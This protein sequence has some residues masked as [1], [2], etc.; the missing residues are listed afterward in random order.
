MLS[1]R[2]TLHHSNWLSPV[3]SFLAL[4]PACTMTFTCYPQSL[5]LSWNTDIRARNNP[6]LSDQK[7]ARFRN[8]T[9]IS[10]RKETNQ[11]LGIFVSSFIGLSY[12]VVWI[13]SLEN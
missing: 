3:A 10:E 5:S 9:S 4:T 1:I 12:L 13:L 6:Q 8:S 7:P 11:T 2:H